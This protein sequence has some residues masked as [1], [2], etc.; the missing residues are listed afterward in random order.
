MLEAQRFALSRR[1]TV[2]GV[3]MVV[4]TVDIMVTVVADPACPTVDST[5]CNGGDIPNGKVCSV[6]S[7]FTH[8][9]VIVT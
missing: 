8:S 5:D 6:R 1:L 7:R 4:A 3:V 9:F 2:A